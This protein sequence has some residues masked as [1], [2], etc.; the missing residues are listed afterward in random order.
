VVKACV[1]NMFTYYIISVFVT[2]M[3]A[4]VEWGEK[5]RFKEC[6]MLLYYQK[7]N[8]TKR[9]LFRNMEYTLKLKDSFL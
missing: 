7:K 9:G 2:Q 4:V 8:G 1:N 5:Y 3:E 6:D